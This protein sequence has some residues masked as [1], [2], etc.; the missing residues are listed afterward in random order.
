MNANKGWAQNADKLRAATASI[1]RN[2]LNS[3]VWKS[4]ARN[5]SE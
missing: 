1:E 5:S 2:V 4:S 3:V